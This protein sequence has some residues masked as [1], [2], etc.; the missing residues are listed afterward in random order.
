MLRT[1]LGVPARYVYTPWQSPW[2]ETTIEQL[3]AVL[4]AKSLGGL[5]A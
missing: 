2:L 5:S 4:A 3:R 1:R